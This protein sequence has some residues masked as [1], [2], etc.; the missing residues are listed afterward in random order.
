MKP[1]YIVASS[2]GESIVV[3]G[4]DEPRQNLT[5]RLSY[6]LA[7]M[8]CILRSDASP[9]KRHDKNPI[10]ADES[11]SFVLFSFQS[12]NPKQLDKG[13]KIR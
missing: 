4:V 7:P 10:K 12:R 3:D 9:Y 11:F 1:W 2:S 13:S 6:L 8:A 5:L